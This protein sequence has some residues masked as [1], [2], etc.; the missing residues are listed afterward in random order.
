MPISIPIPRPRPRPRPNH[1]PHA[2]LLARPYASAAAPRTY[3]R[4]Q[5]AQTNNPQTETFS[6]FSTS[7]TGSA[8]RLTRMAASGNKV[9]VLKL[10][11]IISG[12]V[13]VLYFLYHLAF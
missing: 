10:A 8:S 6:S 4:T 3:T 9:A 2:A 7:L 5:R 12:V 1:V 13:L 11:G